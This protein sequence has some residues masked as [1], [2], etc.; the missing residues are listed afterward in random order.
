MKAVLHTK[1]GPPEELQL[2]EVNKPVPKDNEVLIKI[3]TTT[4]T[5]SDCNVRNLT[6]VSGV[7]R[8]PARLMFGIFKP[9]IKTLG[10]DFAGTIEA[11]GKA[12]KRFKPGD[13][14]FGTPNLKMGTHAEY[15]CLPENGLLLAKPSAITWN[16]AAAVN[17]AGITALYFI[18][19][20]GKVKAGQKVLIN[21]ASGAIGTFAVQLAKYYGAEVTGVCSTANL[22]MVTSLG[23]DKVI[24]YTKTDFTQT[25]ETYDVIF[26]VV[27]K[28]SFSQCK[29]LLAPQGVYLMTITHFGDL[30]AMI[31]H[32]K[33]IKGGMSVPT[34]EGLRF[35]KE[36]MEAGKLKTVVD[37]TFTLD[38]IA[39]AFRYV[40]KGHKKGNVM[41]T[42]NAP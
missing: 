8:L 17:L 21:G 35:L 37:K 39:E 42:V 36:L 12:V 26:D 34:L 10:L 16:E 6:F 3:H 19:D 40:E 41:V 23:A 4:V 28:L 7:F 2:V 20:S 32:G 29:H 15:I 25:N 30:M 13:E 5:S 33:K 9:R 38:Q 1:Y 18:R 11:V 14:V 24:D 31:S 22:Q 27:G